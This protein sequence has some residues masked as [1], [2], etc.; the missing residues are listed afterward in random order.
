[1]ERKKAGRPKKTLRSLSVDVPKVSRTTAWRRKRAQARAERGCTCTEQGLPM[2]HA[3]TDDKVGTEDRYHY[4]EHRLRHLATHPDYD[5]GWSR[6]T[7]ETADA[8][9]DL[10]RDHLPPLETIHPDPLTAKQLVVVALDVAVTAGRYGHR[11][12]E[13]H[14]GPREHLR[15]VRRAATRTTLTNAIMR[16]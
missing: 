14:A 6:P 13:R 9:Y 5:A 3:N 2:L 8:I 4:I 12:E 16:R 1:M 7:R 15:Q 11:A 10:L